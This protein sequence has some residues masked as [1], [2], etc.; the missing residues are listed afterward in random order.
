VVLAAGERGTAGTRSGV[1]QEV[2]N[3]SALSLA[4]K[5]SGG[6][7]GM[8]CGR[9]GNS[10]S[11]AR[12][13]SGASAYCNQMRELRAESWT[14]GPIDGFGL[15]LERRMHARE[16]LAEELDR[17]RRQGGDLD[18]QCLQRFG[19]RAYRSARVA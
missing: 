12:G 18:S 5:S 14:D 15:S 16:R 10:V 1:D 3:Q 2:V 7:G 13:E 6:E 8:R 9:A 17:N 11:C 4:M 19:H